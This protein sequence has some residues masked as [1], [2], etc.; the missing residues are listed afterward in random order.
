MRPNRA[1]SHLILPM[2]CLHAA[3]AQDPSKDR[4]GEH[5]RAG[6]GAEEPLVFQ[7]QTQLVTW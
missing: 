6:D 2:L 4:A 7:S 3:I 1:A 5:V